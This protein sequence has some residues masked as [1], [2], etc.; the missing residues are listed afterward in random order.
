MALLDNG[1]RPSAGGRTDGNR[2]DTATV[3]ISAKEKAAK[4]KSASP[5]AVVTLILLLGLIVAPLIMVFYGAF[6]SGAP[7]L[8]KTTWSLKAILSVYTTPAYIWPL[9]GTLLLAIVTA[10]VSVVFGT[11]FAWLIART[12][13]FLRRTLEWGIIL[14]LF[15]SPFIGAVAWNILG[16]PRSGII[17]TNLR[18]MLGLPDNATI[19]DISTL[20]GVVFVMMLYFLPYGYLL[21]AAS[22]RN[23][24]PGLEEASYMNGRGIV[25]TALRV[26]LPIMRPALTAA[27]FMIAILATGVYTIPLALG[28]NTGFTPLGLQVYLRSTQYPTNQPLAAAIGTLLFWF[29]LLGIYFY[30]R[31]IRNGR[32]FVTLA[33]KAT[34]QRAVKLGWA[35]WPATILVI[36]YGLFAAVLPIV[37]L[38]LIGLSPH[39]QTDFRNM[40]FSMDSFA[41][42]FASADTWHALLNTV[43][44]GLIAPTIAVLLAI[45]VAYV[46]IRER[47]KLGGV[48]DYL[49]TFPVAVP[50][51]VFATGMLWLYIR[52]PIY[53]TVLTLSIALVAGFMPT[54]TRFVSTGLM[55]IDSSLEEAARMSGAN[56]FRAVSTITLPLIRPALLSVWSLL[57]V[58]AS[59]EV[60]ETV[61]LATPNTR[62][63]AVLAWNDIDAN[64]QGAA[65]VVSLLLMV[66]MALGMLLA[67]FVFRAP[68][69]SSNI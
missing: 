26:T 37:A 3:S 38:V 65:A 68:L 14:P 40:R 39:A 17:N 33:G 41:Q 9:I 56:R 51:I 1:S 15:I 50:A 4:R 43:W 29:T 34:R 35:R 24:D 58:F 10:L 42:V 63:L 59:R 57:F 54:A 25:A 49:A 53:A 55:Q 61:L 7:G 46:V 23:M 66:F 18:W 27:F 5:L 44:I 60:N 36:L 20:P 67:R 6:Q 31:A 69:N 64:D 22:L 62:P 13:V 52:T 48:L 47:G 28:V 21:V 19:M 45:A 30:R 32:R 8:P 12:N 11:L 2:P 16:A